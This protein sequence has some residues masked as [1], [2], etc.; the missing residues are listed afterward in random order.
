M[1]QD[2]GKATVEALNNIMGA[3][4]VVEVIIGIICI[5]S[6]WKIFT[7]AGQPGWAS[8]IPFFNLYILIKISEKPVWWL[9]LF[10]IPCVN[11]IAAILIAVALA[12]KFGKG[13]LFAVGLILLPFIFYPILAFSDAQYQGSAAP[14]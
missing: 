13:G 3:A 2:G 4:L 9:I 14:M 10:L 5:L 6:L 12:E 11:I 7:K 8:I 1:Q